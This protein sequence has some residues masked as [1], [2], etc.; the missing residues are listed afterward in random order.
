MT[1]STLI[2][3][4]KPFFSQNEVASAVHDIFPE[5]DDTSCTM[6]VLIALGVSNKEACELMA[7]SINCFNRKLRA[8]ADM[9]SVPVSNLRNIVLV[10]LFLILV[11]KP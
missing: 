6:V 7:M 4:I 9:Y 3:Y 5:L 10:R 8:I 1:D 2:T 11:S